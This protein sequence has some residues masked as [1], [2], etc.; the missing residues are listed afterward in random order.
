MNYSYGA[1]TV[2]PRD[3]WQG[4]CSNQKEGPNLIPP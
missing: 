4:E 2:E 3:R 1:K